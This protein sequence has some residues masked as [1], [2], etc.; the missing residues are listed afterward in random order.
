MI[1]HDRNRVT[2]MNYQCSF[3]LRDTFRVIDLKCV[4]D[5][6]FNVSLNYDAN[7]LQEHDGGNTMNTILIIHCLK[8]MIL[9][10]FKNFIIREM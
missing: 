8:L 4:Y 2:Q 9:Y 6:N 10:N 7:I 1:D 5:D 3:D